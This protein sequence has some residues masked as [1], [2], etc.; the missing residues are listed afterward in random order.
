MIEPGVTFGK[1]IPRLKQKGLKLMV[2]LHPRA[3]KSV[4]TAALERVPISIPRYMWDS[5]DPLLC[6]EVIFG[7]GEFFRTG[8]A[9]GPGSIKEQRRTG[10]AQVNPM[11]PT[12][13][14]P[15]RII[16]GAQ[17]SIGIVTWATLK[18]E[19]LP[20]QQK[21]YHLQSDNLQDLLDI[22]HELLKYRLCDE[23]LILNNLNLACLI[24]E[25]SNEILRSIEKFKKWNLIFVLSGRG[26]LARDRISYLEGDLEDILKT[27]KVS[28]PDKYSKVEDDSILQFLSQ[29]DHHSWKLRLSGAHQDIFFI[30]SLEK[31]AEFISIV[32]TQYT[33]HLGIYIQAINQGT[34]YHC[35]FNLYYDPNNENEPIKINEKFQTIST[36]LMDLGAFF[37]RP[38]GLWAS[39]VFKRHQYSTQIALRK[40]KNIFDPN[41]V[42]NPGV[43]C[44]DENE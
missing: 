39:E 29:S 24:E 34:S 16:Q 44:F 33:G 21:V 40:I 18:L 31:L 30:T 41:K 9:A 3:S 14:S 37:N 7:N 19:L 28:V 20:T 26:E 22:Q 2:P 11:G 25:D 13:F 38:Y 15:F 12:Q 42:L 43:L 1:L 17:G 5:S 32:E 6:T 36:E 4:L 35:E 10:Q 8:T 23:L 27:K